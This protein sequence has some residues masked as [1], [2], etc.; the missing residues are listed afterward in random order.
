[1]VWLITIAILVTFGVSLI[2]LD[3]GKDELTGPSQEDGDDA[4]SDLPAENLLS[5]E[6]MTTQYFVSPTGIFKPSVGYFAVNLD[7][8]G[9]GTWLSLFPV[10]GLNDSFTYSLS[11]DGTFT[12][13]SKNS[14]SR[15]IVSADG[16]SF[17]LVRIDND[18][19]YGIAVG[20]AR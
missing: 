14:E 10:E 1:M 13:N 9:N 20:I 16:K 8:N 7:G 11:E 17:T 5:G 4:P 12:N 2:Y 15:G 6:Y 19:S 3:C 18:G